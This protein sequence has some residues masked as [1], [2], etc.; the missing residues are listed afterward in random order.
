MDARDNP[1]ASFVIDISALIA[2][3]GAEHLVVGVAPVACPYCGSRETETTLI[4][5]V[6]H[7]RELGPNQWSVHL[8]G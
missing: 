5:S 3:R 4:V 2:E 1:P 7:L 8:S 6:A